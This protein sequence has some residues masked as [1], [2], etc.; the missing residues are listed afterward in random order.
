M[1]ENLYYFFFYKQFK[2]YDVPELV[3]KNKCYL[4]QGWAYVYKEDLKSVLVSTF[5]KKLMRD[6]ECKIQKKFFELYQIYKT[7][8]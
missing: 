3:G 4:E 1:M 8:K 2:F 6:L 5:R 7:E